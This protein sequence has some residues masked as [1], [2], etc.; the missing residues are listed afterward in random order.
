MRKW[1]GTENRILVPL[2]VLGELRAGFATGTRRQE[3]EELLQQFLDSP[4]VDTVALTNRTTTFFADV[5]STRH[6]LLS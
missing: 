4:N 5:F 6:A 3:N 2:I 1:I